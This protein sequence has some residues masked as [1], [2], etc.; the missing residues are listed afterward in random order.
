MIEMMDLS[1]EELEERFQA[2]VTWTDGVPY[3]RDT[4]VSVQTIIDAYPDT[5]T[6]GEHYPS[7]EPLDL[8]WAGYYVGVCEEEGKCSTQH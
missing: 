6:L 1:P 2:W 4:G 8:F 3:V 5:Q 7:L